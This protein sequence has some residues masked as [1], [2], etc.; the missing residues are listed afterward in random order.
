MEWRLGRLTAISF[1]FG[2]LGGGRPIHRRA[3]FAIGH[4]VQNFPRDRATFCA[5]CTVPKMGH[6][7]P[8][9]AEVVPQQVRSN[10]RQVEGLIAFMC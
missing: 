7:K 4:N 6:K 9:G 10:Q 1:L 5:T 2:R 3:E 8:V